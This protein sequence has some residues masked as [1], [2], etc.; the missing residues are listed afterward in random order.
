M[1]SFLL[2]SFYTVSLLAPAVAWS[3]GQELAR[4]DLT[5]PSD[6]TPEPVQEFDITQKNIQRETQKSQENTTDLPENHNSGSP[7]TISLSKEELARQPELLHRA[8]SSSVLMRDLEGIRTLL[9]IYQQQSENKDELLSD[10]ASAL[11]A[12]DDGEAGKA[13][14]LYKKVL[15]KQA[16]IPAAK[17]G[18]AQSLFDDRQNREADAAFEAIQAEADLPDSVRE[19]TESYRKILKKRQK[20]NFY[21]NAHYVRDKNVNN[22]PSVRVVKT[23]NGE[24]RLPE[25]K[26]AQGFAYRAGMSKDT[27]LFQ[28]YQFRTNVDLWGKFYWDNHAYDDVAARA[29]AGVAY[30][31][32][33]TEVAALPYYE[34]RWFGTE[35]YATEKGGRLELSHWLSNKNQLMLAGE[36]GR[37]KYDTR[38]FLN[39]KMGQFSS[40]VTHIPNK[41]QYFSVGFDISRKSAQDA[42]DAYRRKGIRASWSQHW[43]RL[44]L[45]STV[46]A[47]YGQRSYDAQDFFN[48]VRKDRELSATVSLWHKKVQWLGI[49]PRLVAV[50]QRHRSNHVLYDYRKA[51]AFLQLSKS[52]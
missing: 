36:L 39:G 8:L 14:K 38:T 2:K 23:R 32:A 28:N 17:L 20:I 19:L 22:A 35:K 3:G 24:W 44:G 12:R 31:N 48:V 52:I 50:Y 33:K 1:S 47:Q 45:S 46:S 41:N 34:R 49:Q 11:L 37:D 10:W 13:A 21:A 42:S 15:E 29:S 51:Y 25:P 16:D 7:K 43:R 9:P 27:P 30:T 4:N 40:T 18:L 26:R 6:L 5:S